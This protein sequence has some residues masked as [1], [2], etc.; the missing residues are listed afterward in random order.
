MLGRPDL[1]LPWAVLLGVYVGGR[2]EDVDERVKYFKLGNGICV[3]RWYKRIKTMMNTV[4]AYVRL[5]RGMMLCLSLFRRTCCVRVRA[6]DCWRGRRVQ[7]SY[8]RD[9]VNRT[10]TDVAIECRTNSLIT[11][12]YYLERISIST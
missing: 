12:K 1:Q 9:D 3:S 8:K 10:A 4:G 11:S 2:A 6:A 5:K 7:K